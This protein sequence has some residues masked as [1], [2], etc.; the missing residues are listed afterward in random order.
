MQRSF[1]SA[2]AREAELRKSLANQ[3]QEVINLSDQLVEYKRLSSIKDSA[4]EMR[5]AAMKRLNEIS[6]QK[7]VDQN[8]I[9]VIQ[10][11]YVPEKPIKPDKVR[12]L[13][14]GLM[15][16]LLLV[17]LRLRRPYGQVVAIIARDEQRRGDDLRQQV[18]RILTLD[19]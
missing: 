1:E 9:S 7:D 6:T 5:D 2:K 8:K 15:S 10:S 18:L 17:L 4:R 11:A 14:M 19:D 13:L 16:G 12:I 3:K